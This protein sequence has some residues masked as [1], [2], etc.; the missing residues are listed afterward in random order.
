MTQEQANTEIKFFNPYV[1]DMYGKDESM[2]KILVL[3]ASFYC[4]ETKRSCYKECTNSDKKDSRAFDT[5]CP[6]YKEIHKE[7]PEYALSNEPKIAIKIDHYDATS[8]QNF[9]MFLQAVLLREDPWGYVAFTNYI[10]FM[11]PS[12]KTDARLISDRDFDAF[13]EVVKKIEPDVIITW[14]NE[15]KEHIN[16]IIRVKQPYIEYELKKN[17]HYLFHAKVGGREVTMVNLYHPSALSYWCKDLRNSYEY[18][19]MA[20]DEESNHDRQGNI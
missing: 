11:L 9:E 14:G 15:I 5:S 7:N 12:W 2:K 20:L 1:G 10:Q 18:V 19:K 3:G 6:V 17:N 13:E 8:Y 16:N 4:G